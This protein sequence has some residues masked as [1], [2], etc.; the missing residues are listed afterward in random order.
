MT[1]CASYGRADV[2]RCAS[3]GRADLTRYD[4][5]VCLTVVTCE[6]K[7][8]AKLPIRVSHQEVTFK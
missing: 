6:A 3:Y 8:T 7:S 2:T 4:V 1:R 5:P